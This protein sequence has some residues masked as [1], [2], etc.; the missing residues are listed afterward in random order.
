MQIIAKLPQ[1]TDVPEVTEIFNLA[2]IAPEV[3]KSGL[4]PGF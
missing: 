2:H 4:T 1:S 3:V